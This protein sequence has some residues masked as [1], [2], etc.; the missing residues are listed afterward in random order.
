MEAGREM[1]RAEGGGRVLALQQESS[2][3]SSKQ[4]IFSEGRKQLLPGQGS[5]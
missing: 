2:H 3:K 1:R 5:M 4:V